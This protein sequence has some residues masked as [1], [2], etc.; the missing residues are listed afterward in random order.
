MVAT[1]AEWQEGWF[2]LGNKWLPRNQILL[3]SRFYSRR[4]A[5]WF[6]FDKFGTTKKNQ[7]RNGS[8]ANKGEK[9][10]ITPEI[11]GGNRKQHST[12]MVTEQMS[13]R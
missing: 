12:Q 5:P 9:R 7:Q 3:N 11:E 8:A 6:D 10:P 2:Q 1:I 13:L 4:P